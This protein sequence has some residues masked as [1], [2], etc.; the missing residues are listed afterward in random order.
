VC[1]QSIDGITFM[2]CTHRIGRITLSSECTR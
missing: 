2:R 1:T